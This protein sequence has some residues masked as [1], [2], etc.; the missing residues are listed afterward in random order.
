VRITSVRVQNFGSYKELNFDFQNQG[1]TLIQGPTGAGKSTL[2]DAIPWILFGRT[3]KGGNIDEVCSWDGKGCTSGIIRLGDGTIIVRTRNINDLYID[4]GTADSLGAYP[5]NNA[6]RIRGKD[7]RD[8]QKLIDELLGIDYETYLAGAYFHEFSQTAQFFT[9]TAKI[10]RQICEQIVD[11]STAKN[12]QL[13]IS[14]SI[15]DQQHCAAEIQ[16]IINKLNTEISTLKNIN[17]TEKLRESR[18]EAEH[19]KTIEYVANLSN[20]FENNRKRVISKQCTL[21]RTVL[22]HPHEVVDNSENPHKARLQELEKETNPF[23]SSAKDYSTKIANKK[24]QLAEN[25]SDLESFTNHINDLEVLKDVS[26]AFRS[27]LI[28][29]TIAY[30]EQSTNDILTRHFDA[31]IQVEFNATDNDKLEVLITK[32]GNEASFTQLSKGQRQLLK[33]AFGVS[34]MK[35]VSNH[36]GVHF[37]Q[38]FFDEF[39]DGLD[40]SLKIKAFDL[41]QELSLSHESV[42]AI[43]HSESLKSLFTNKFSVELINGISTIN[44]A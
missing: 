9:T 30:T 16:T 44:P 11:L 23:K 40:E 10:R 3:A 6:K 4:I 24:K 38:L 19:L 20:K 7:L 39:A 13:K 12:L 5:H 29:N 31:E 26:E 21:C 2:M 37:S 1:L 27:T 33:L 14:E 34:V 15:K 43:D 32:D 17:E 36:K 8:T 25:K 22:E 18:W 41:L 35:G 28:K 42:F